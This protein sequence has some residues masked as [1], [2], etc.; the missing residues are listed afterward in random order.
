MQKSS[1]SEGQRGR[2]WNTEQLTVPSREISPHSS[3]LCGAHGVG[4]GSAESR[5]I[6]GMVRASTVDGLDQSDP[7]TAEAAS[8]V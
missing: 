7:E 8:T 6:T 3:H 4:R 1:R 5:T 2:M